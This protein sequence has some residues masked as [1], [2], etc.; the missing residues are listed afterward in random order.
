[1]NWSVHLEKFPFPFINVLQVAVQNE[2]SSGYPEPIIV[3][4]LVVLNFVVCRYKLVPFLNLIH[5]VLRAFWVVR[6]GQHP[7]EVDQTNHNEGHANVLVQ[8]VFLFLLEVLLDVEFLISY[9]L[10][11]TPVSEIL[12]L[13]IE[14]LVWVKWHL[15]RD[16]DSFIDWSS[17]S[18]RV[19]QIVNLSCF[20]INKID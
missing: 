11:G 14:L 20:T 19:F 18:D 2:V 4:G 1:M 8:F 15:I 6:P 13:V 17:W 9:Q 16:W 10:R 7:P 12:Q 5:L 3:W